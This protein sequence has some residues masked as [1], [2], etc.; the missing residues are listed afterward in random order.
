MRPLKLTICAFGPYA[1]EVTVDMDRLG[2]RGLYLISGDTG[3]GKT[4]I[5]DA[6][7]FALYGEAS[8]AN[9]EADM[10]RSKYADP[11]TP[12]FVEMEFL[13]SQKI[14]TVRRN[15]EYMR[16]SRKGGGF[17]SQK[18][19]ALL[20]FPDGRVV[21]GAKNVTKETEKLLGIDRSQFMQIAM[22]AQ[23]EF[24]K[25]LLA[26]TK[27]RGEIF[28]ELFHTGPYQRLQERLKADAS[29]AREEYE[30]LC[31][32][33]LQYVGGIKGTAEE[34]E[35]E[36]LD[37]IKSAGNIT[38][39]EDAREF[40]DCRIREDS[41]L[42]EKYKK[43]EKELDKT[44][45]DIHRALEKALAEK[46]IRDGIEEKERQL[47]KEKPLLEEKLAAYETQK[48]M[49]GHREELSLSV[50][51]LQESIQQYLI[52]KKIEK[53]AGQAAARLKNLEQQREDRKRSLERLPRQLEKSRAELAGLGDIPMKKAEL[54]HE[55]KRLQEEE[56]RLRELQ[57]KCTELEGLYGQLGELQKKYMEE[58]GK[59][60]AT[61][62]EYDK[63][64]QEY[65]DGQAGVLAAHLRE[66]E[67]CPV[68]GSLSHP[69][70]A[71]HEGSIPSQEQL[72][73]AKKK[74]DTA[75]KKAYDLSASAG[76]LKGRAET[77][78]R[79]VTE[80][81]ASWQLGEEP[82]EVRAGAGALLDRQSASKGEI[83]KQEQ[84][85]AAGLKRRSELE[86]EIPELEARI[87]REQKETGEIEKLAAGLEAEQKA[88]EEERARML[89]TL[90]YESEKAA[91]EKLEEQ[92]QK[93]AELDR[94][95]E[96]SKSEYENQN[97]RINE[98]KAQISALKGQQTEGEVQ[99]ADQLR[100]RESEISQEKERLQETARE[101]YT[102]LG[103]N[104]GVAEAIAGREKLLLEAQKRAGWMKALSDTA[105]GG[106]SGKERIM[107]ETYIQMVYFERILSRANTRLMVMTGGQ[108]ELKRRKEAGNLKSQS[109]LELDVVDHYNGTLRSVKTLSGG[110]SFKASLSLALGLS[111]EIQSQA[112]GIQLDTMFVDEGF[113]SLDEESLEMALNVLSHLTEGN[114]L[115]GIISHVSELKER[116]DRQIV[117]SKEKARGSSVKIV[118]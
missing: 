105:N 21:S 42:W 77:L 109:G 49:A 85:L 87:E 39:L 114:C 115:V 47:E 65:L 98:L 56:G 23:D 24:L 8:G 40:L 102:R 55:L 61:G 30:E 117:V 74:R 76:E 52:L 79:T 4:T 1:G 33:I 68:C 70:P 6:V 35:Q 19:D 94:L 95:F 92:K 112:G 18:A 88:K 108:Y 106:V 14:Y 69:L 34:E 96:K 58:A 16:P 22:I 12:T 32:S 25:L 17:T 83:S 116:I 50:T 44:L 41:A 59:A 73:K 64:E 38:V 97:I 63:L 72:E 53:E 51:R 111:D 81:A 43:A 90:D 31:R 45:A 118:V 103:T 37:R 9:R 84:L 80:L 13:Y 67:P 60:R 5:F 27:E 54:E 46:K 3:A 11:E 26:T 71:A 36:K 57:K 99:D 66:N 20:T 29:A 101:V 15:P 104:T 62:M 28:R 10:F 113:G 7:V 82:G 78:R 75:Q 86:K 100:D 89:L 93:K 2:D 48:S 107:L 110:E 91:R